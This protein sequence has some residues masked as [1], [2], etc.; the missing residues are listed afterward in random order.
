MPLCYSCDYWL[1]K[2]GLTS[3]QH[4]W[5]HTYNNKIFHEPVENWKGPWLT[6]EI[7]T[8]LPSLYLFNWL[9]LR[10]KH[11]F[12]RSIFTHQTLFELNLWNARYKSLT[13]SYFVITYLTRNF[14]IFKIHLSGDK[15]STTLR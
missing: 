5:K 6:N 10:Q 12:H 15:S 11:S 8:K 14:G 1:Y 3:L 7:T 4:R 13:N 9:L 2:L